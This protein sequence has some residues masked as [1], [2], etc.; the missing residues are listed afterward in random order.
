MSSNHRNYSIATAVA[1]LILLVFVFRSAEDP[2][3][4]DSSGQHGSRLRV[5]LRTDGAERSNENKAELEN[6]HVRFA[7]SISDGFFK[8]TRVDPANPRPEFPLLDEN[9]IL[10]SQ[11]IDYAN[12]DS[13]EAKE[14]QGYVDTM[15]AALTTAAADAV[16][17][18][19]IRADPENGVYAFRIA[20]YADVGQSIRSEFSEKVSNLIS[21]DRAERLFQTFN[22]HD[23]FGACGEV[24]TLVTF[25]EVRSGNGSM[26]LRAEWEQRHPE[27]GKRIR[28][29][30]A[31]YDDFVRTYGQIVTVESVE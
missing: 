12:V 25:R 23:F 16:E 30:S 24:E 19:T 6:G 26:V 28:S 1:A 13:K 8:P 18:D 31:A 15:K 7:T 17:V 9:F 29:T 4:I 10:T 21:R 11:S 27:T 5:N 3:Q 20:P 14:I 2:T 22:W